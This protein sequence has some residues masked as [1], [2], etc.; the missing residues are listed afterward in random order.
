MQ[1][2]RRLQTVDDVLLRLSVGSNDRGKNGCKNDQKNEK[3]RERRQLILPA[4]AQ[5]LLPDS[6][7]FSHLTDQ[8]P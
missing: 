8:L 6:V 5:Q 2:T 3:R 7:L 1:R 4:H